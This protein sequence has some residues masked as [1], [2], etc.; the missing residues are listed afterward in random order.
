MPAVAAVTLVGAVALVVLIAWR[1]GRDRL[2][3][4]GAY[5]AVFGTAGGA[6]GSSPWPG[7]AYHGT[8]WHGL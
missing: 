2:L 1:L 7:C 3:P 5:L 8:W 4:P 6:C